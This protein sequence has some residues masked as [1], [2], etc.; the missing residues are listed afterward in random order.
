[1]L[2]IKVI[3][4]HL[5]FRCLPLVRALKRKGNCFSLIFNFHGDDV[6]VCTISEDFEH[7]G[8]VHAHADGPVAPEL[9]KAVGSHVYSHQQDMRVVHTLKL[10]AFVAPIQRG[11]VQ[12]IFHSLQNCFEETSLDKPGLKH[13]DKCLV[14]S[15]L[16]VLLGYERFVV[17]FEI[18]LFL[19]VLFSQ[20][21]YIIRASFCQ[22]LKI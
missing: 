22:K 20:Q 1:M 3:Q 2:L 9:V 5:I 6:F 8:E 21:I 12:E 19:S 13:L 10:D 14:S 11:L 16:K 7:L 18:I 17:N 15:L 4:L